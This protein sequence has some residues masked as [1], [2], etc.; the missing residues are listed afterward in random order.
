MATVIPRTRAQIGDYDYSPVVNIITWILLVAMVLSVCSKV[1]IKIIT[2]R[3]FN[4][5]NVVLIL[6]MVSLEI[7]I[8]MLPLTTFK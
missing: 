3:T 2:C 4:M 5:D 1:A 7:R 8:A 6:A